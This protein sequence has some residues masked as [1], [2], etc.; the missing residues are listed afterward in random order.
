MSTP[1]P[2]PNPSEQPNPN[3]QQNLGEQPQAYEQQQAYQQQYGAQYQGQYQ[4]PYQGQNQQTDQGQYQQPYQAQYQQ[5]YQQQYA[6]YQQQY[7][8]GYQQ[9][10][11]NTYQQPYTGNQQPY[12][13]PYQPLPHSSKAIAALVLMIISLLI[14][15]LPLFNII[16]IVCAIIAIVLGKQAMQ[17][18]SRPPFPR[19]REMAGT[20]VA[21]GAYSI[22]FAAC[23]DV[24]VLIMVAASL[25]GVDTRFTQ[26]YSFLDT[27]KSISAEVKTTHPAMIFWTDGENVGSYTMQEKGKWTRHFADDGNNHYAV[28]AIADPSVIQ[29]GS[30]NFSLG[31]SL[32]EEEHEI[33]N[34]RISSPTN[35]VYCSSLTKKD[36]PVMKRLLKKMIKTY[37]STQIPGGDSYMSD[38]ELNNLAQGLG[39]SE[40]STL[41][42]T[43]SK[44]AEDMIT[45]T[46]SGTDS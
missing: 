37:I 21:L 7:Q 31:C 35:F 36:V 3:E 8:P 16:S 33:T 11:Q 18:T 30:I 41:D 39:M 2:Q 19:G 38:D 34:S 15:W 24:M 26:P 29:N 13:Q 42:E 27:T 9:P 12:Q 25:S 28:I 14:C 45:N 1:N 43:L 22:F 6:G 4:G 40:G 5:Q 20:S 46:T 17:E 44:I 23:V 32:K 10:Y